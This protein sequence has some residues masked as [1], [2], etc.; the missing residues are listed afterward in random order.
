[1]THGLVVIMALFVEGCNEMFSYLST[2]FMEK[3]SLGGE[4]EKIPQ[5]IKKDGGHLFIKISKRY[6]PSHYIT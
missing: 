3:F 1:M 5:R 2:F 4:E 6:K